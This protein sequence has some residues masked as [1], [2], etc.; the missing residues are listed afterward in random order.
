MNP[1]VTNYRVKCSQASDINRHLPT[2]YRYARRSEVIAEFGV[3]GI[4]STWAF[5]RGLLENGSQTKELICVD[6]ADVPEMEQVRTLAGHNGI[7]L[8]FHQHDSATCVIPEVDLLFVDT[9]HVYGHLKRELNNHCERVRKYILMHDTELDGILGESRRFGWNIKEQ[10]AKSGYPEEEIACGLQRAIS[11]FLAKHS[12]WR[13]IRRYRH[14][15][16]LTILARSSNVRITPLDRTIAS[17]QNSESYCNLRN[18]LSRMYRS[19]GK[20]RSAQ[21]ADPSRG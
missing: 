9:W 19:G 11:E 12:Q 17:V 8:T 14:C 1:I 2:L 16:G 7:R 21:E 20:R 5:L 10:A 3:R 18:Y 6:I 13:L 4:V 15:C